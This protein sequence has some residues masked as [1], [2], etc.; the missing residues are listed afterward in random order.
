[1][2]QYEE[3]DVPQCDLIEI[4][5]VSVECTAAIFRIKEYAKQTRSNQQAE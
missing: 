2:I 1:M 5:R 3:K 4:Y